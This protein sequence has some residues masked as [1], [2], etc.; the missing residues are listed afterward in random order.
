MAYA[1]SG[2]KSQAC[3]FIRSGA[4][5]TARRSPPVDT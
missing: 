4:S 2:C 1:G 5:P 3:T